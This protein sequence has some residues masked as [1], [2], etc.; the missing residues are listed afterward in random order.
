MLV[1]ERGEFLSG[2]QR[3]CVAIARAALMSPSIMLFDEPTSAMDFSTE[4]AFIKKMEAYG[5]N[6]TMV[7]V[8]HR[9]SLLALA[10]RVIVMDQGRVV[11]DGPKDAVIEALNSG[12]LSVAS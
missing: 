9:M 7:I 4:S 6:K 5:E 10:K 8:T 12:K 1:G 2:G 3:Q 11:A